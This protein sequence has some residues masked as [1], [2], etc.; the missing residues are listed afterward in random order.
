MFCNVQII[1]FHGKIRVAVFFIATPW[2]PHCSRTRSHPLTYIHGKTTCCGSGLKFR[3]LI[4]SHCSCR[5]KCL[6]SCTTRWRRCLRCVGGRW[7]PTS[8]PFTCWPT[9]R[10]GWRRSWSAWT[11]Y[12]QRMWKLSEPQ[13]RRRRDLSEFSRTFLSSHIQEHWFPFY[14]IDVM[15]CFCSKGCARKRWRWRNF[16]MRKDSKWL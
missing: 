3:L 9:Q 2:I 16:T 13:R 4:N 15:F 12:L 11:R 7:E 5:I 10:A 6:K 14:T 8:A 1:F